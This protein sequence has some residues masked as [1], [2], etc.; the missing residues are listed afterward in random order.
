MKYLPLDTEVFKKTY[1][2]DASG[3]VQDKTTFYVRKPNG[4]F[5]FLVDGS[6]DPN[7]AILNG[8]RIPHKEGYVPY[9]DVVLLPTNVIEIEGKGQPGETFTVKISKTMPD[10]GGNNQDGSFFG[11]YMRETDL[12]MILE[13]TNKG[14][15]YIVYRGISAL[16]PWEEFFRPE[17]DQ[18]GERIQTMVNYD[19][20]D[21]RHKTYCYRAEAFDPDG[22]KVRDYSPFCLPFWTDEMEEMENSPRAPF[23]PKYL[24]NGVCTRPGDIDDPDCMEKQ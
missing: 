21:T 24:P 23:P 7:E 15:L 16:G 19:L 3:L 11:S 13:A 17:T 12:M 9:G 10:Q 22:N 2:F 14:V 1:T 8:K 20:E 4:T 6:G 5:T 18:P